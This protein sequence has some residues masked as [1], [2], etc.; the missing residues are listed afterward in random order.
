[1]SITDEQY[2][3]NYN[4]LFSTV[5]WKQLLSELEDNLLEINKVENVKSS[6]D[7]C[8]RKG[9]IDILNNILSLEIQ[10]E[11]ASKL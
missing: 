4:D 11:L 8:F 2:N 10:L 9:Q 1:M 5:G 3:D 7:L 6:D